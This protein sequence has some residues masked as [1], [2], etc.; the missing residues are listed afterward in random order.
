MLQ[1]NAC[2]TATNK[3]M[4]RNLASMACWLWKCISHDFW[5]WISP[6]VRMNMKITYVVNTW[7]K[8]PL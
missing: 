8:R 6:D 7:Q 3:Q 5:P 4:A 1:I 2:Q